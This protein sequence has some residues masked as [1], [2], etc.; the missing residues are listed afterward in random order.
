MYSKSSIQLNEHRASKFKGN[1]DNARVILDEIN[2]IVDLFNGLDKTIKD[3]IG[4]TDSKEP[5]K[6]I[7]KAYGELH[8]G[9]IVPAE[10]KFP[11]LRRYSQSQGE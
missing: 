7:W 2:D 11:D 10:S 6:S 1:H 5:V 4:E 3:E 9:I 8:L